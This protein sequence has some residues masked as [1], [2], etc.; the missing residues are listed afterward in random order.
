MPTRKPVKLPGPTVTA[1]RSS[2]VKARSADCITR[3]I[4]GIS[5]SAWP[6]FIRSDLLR[7]QLAGV[8]VENG[9]RARLQR[10]IDGKDQHRISLVGSAAVEPV[11]V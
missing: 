1:M 2:D 8:G 3:A 4:I 7:K 6:R 11:Q 5:A 9:S 10:G